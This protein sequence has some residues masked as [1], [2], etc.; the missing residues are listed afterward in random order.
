MDT[1]VPLPVPAPTPAQRWF[2]SDGNRSHLIAIL[3]RFFKDKCQWDVEDRVTPEQWFACCRDVEASPEI[4]GA[5]SF[6]TLED[7]VEARNRI[8]LK[9]LQRPLK[10][11]WERLQHASHDGASASAGA[12]GPPM[13]VLPNNP[14]NDDAFLQKLEELQHARDRPPLALRIAPVQPFAHTPTERP[15]CSA[16]VLTS[17]NL[18]EV[19]PGAWE[20]SG[21]SPH[22]LMD[23][24]VACV[25]VPT[26]WV[27]ASP[28][29]PCDVEG[30]G[31]NTDRW[32]FHVVRSHGPWTLLEPPT[33]AC[34]HVRPWALPWTLRWPVAATS[35]AS[36]ASNKWWIFFET[37]TPTTG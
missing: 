34:G 30:A 24:R 29:L 36:T 28:W 19:G 5:A 10:Q 22:G 18:K 20:W 15:R 7:A 13:A 9:M 35:V 4:R 1:P 16:W 37:L 32:H 2:R 31:K 17:A 12:F 6:A 33:A 25:W 26:E 14:L 11:A 23:T 3:T 21:P 8:A 27:R